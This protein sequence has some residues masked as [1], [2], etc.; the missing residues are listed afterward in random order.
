MRRTVL[1]QQGSCLIGQGVIGI[2]YHLRPRLCS[3]MSYDLP[4][5]STTSSRSSCPDML[6]PSN[7]LCDNKR[8]NGCPGDWVRGKIAYVTCDARLSGP[9]PPGEL[10]TGGFCI[11]PLFISVPSC[12]RMASCSSMKLHRQTRFT[13]IFAGMHKVRKSQC[14]ACVPVATADAHEV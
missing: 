8:F 14:T 1:H 2:D 6:G 9:T 3:R 12:R 4:H 11:I 13:P 7:I 10:L 5:F